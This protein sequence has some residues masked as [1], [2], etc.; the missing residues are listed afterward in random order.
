MRLGYENDYISVSGRS[1][2]S[3]NVQIILERLGGGGHLTMA[4][5]QLRGY[6]MERAV[7]ELKETITAYIRENGSA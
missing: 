5:A 4:G 1:L 7:S 6:T 2:G 3:I